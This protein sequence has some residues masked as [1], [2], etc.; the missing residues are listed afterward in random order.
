MNK[1]ENEN[2]LKLIFEGTALYI[3]KQ[4][5]YKMNNK[6][7]Q[8][9]LFG[10]LNAKS[11]TEIMKSYGKTSTTIKVCYSS[12][13]SMALLPDN[14][15]ACAA[16]TKYLYIWDI[17]T[18]Q[19]LYT[20]YDE[21]L[22]TWVDAL[23]SGNPIYVTYYS[24]SVLNAK[25][26]YSLLKRTNFE[27]YQFLSNLQFLSN[28]QIALTP[29]KHYN[30]H[31][32]IIIYN[33]KKDCVRCIYTESSQIYSFTNLSNNR[34]A[35]GSSDYFIHVWSYADDY[36]HVKSI[37]AFSAYSLLFIEK[38]NLLLS[39]GGDLVIKVWKADNYQWINTFEYH[40]GTIRCLL[41]L[42][43]GYF[44]SGSADGNI[45]LWDFKDSQCVN[46]LNQKAVIKCFRLLKDGRIVTGQDSGN[47][48]IW[49]Y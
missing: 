6:S 1:F 29:G 5:I 36:N 30:Y 17:N 21:H 12:I 25:D 45:K 19:C 15:I 37:N 44:A 3:V 24:L 11:T 22:I 35:F 9:I 16:N 42:P 48:T 18:S 28:G 31:N 20:I 46:S 47:I 27:G 7:L 10:K 41:L 40:T 32:S 14:K 33:P 43:S 8:G 39:G 4:L 23:P 34:F 49:D 26:N 13:T 2:I 38:Y